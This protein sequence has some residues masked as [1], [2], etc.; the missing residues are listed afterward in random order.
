MSCEEWQEARRLW[1]DDEDSGFSVAVSHAADGTAWIRLSCSDHGSI[2]AATRWDLG[3]MNVAAEVH[4][5]RS[6]LRAGLKAAV[7]GKAGRGGG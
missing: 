1:P 3:D 5:A 4:Y 6:H 2:Q 7:S